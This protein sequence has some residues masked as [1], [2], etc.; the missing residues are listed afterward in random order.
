MQTARDLFDLYVLSQEVMPLRPFMQSLPSA[1]PAA[2]FDNGL[3][4]M[5]WFELMDELAKIKRV[6]GRINP[7]SPHNVVLV[8][9]TNWGLK[10]LWEVV[11][12][13]VTYAVVGYLKA[14]EGVDVFDNDTD[15]SPFAKAP[16]V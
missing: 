9:V 8:L 2:A 5:P 14:R 11:L 6:L 10:V 1:Y 16:A 7:A 15:F 13:P 12:T 4:S 3:A